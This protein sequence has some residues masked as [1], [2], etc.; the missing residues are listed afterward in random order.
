MKSLFLLP[1][2]YAA[3]NEPLEIKTVLGSCVSVVLVDRTA[4]CMGI[5]HYLLTSLPKSEAPTGRYGECAIPL[6]LQDM[7]KLGAKIE[8]MQAHVFGGA[9]V[10][11]D[12]QI[13][14]EVGQLNIEY[15]FQTLR[16]LGIPIVEKNVGG[17][18]SRK[19]VVNSHDFSVKEVLL[20]E[21][22]A[23]EIDITGY[24]KLKQIKKVKV[25][26]VDDSATIR[27]LFQNIFN[28][29]GLEVVGVAADAYQ[30]R[31]LIVSKKPDVI[32]LD[33][34]MPKMNGVVFL[35]KLMQSM[36]LPV[37][38]VSSLGN[39]G[40]AALKAL[41]LGAVEFMH[42]PTQFDPQIL[43]QLGEMLVEK[44]KA[45]ANVKVRKLESQ[46][47]NEK[48]AVHVNEKNAFIAGLNIIA[49]GGNIGS[50]KSL[51]TLLRSLP[52]DSPPVVISN[53]TISG[54]LDAY[55]KEIQRGIS[56]EL[57]VASDGEILKSGCVYFAPAEIH[58]KV[59][60]QS[61]NFIAR[62]RESM[63]I[64]GQKPSIDVLF[65]SIAKCANAKA[66]GI[67]MS[68]FGRD[69]VDGLK[70]L[71]AAGSQ[72]MVEE[73]SACD[74]PYAPQQ[75]ISVGVVDYIREAKDFVTTV[76]QVRN[77]SVA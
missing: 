35:E 7:E 15:A 13:G 48:H 9:N 46:K 5:N 11:K 3:F 14:K 39:Q 50:Q 62:L 25:L 58:L 72:T 8:Q 28:K 69:G 63:P 31:E 36:P 6:L 42:K 44:V 29:N 70:S 1:G 34:E 41:S 59:V 60:D 18:K 33:I 2:K 21:S 23:Q 27:T 56:V 73:P 40:E 74:F 12:V 47:I 76:M 51:E 24:K 45:A 64:N 16:T 53:S 75:A 38:M 55:L 66:I 71:H 10:L 19:V 54:F 61:S 57:R 4:K 65:S 17:I 37:V 52:A 22:E 26:I 30:A 43:K 20:N 32:T 68:G 67:L 49:V 77:R